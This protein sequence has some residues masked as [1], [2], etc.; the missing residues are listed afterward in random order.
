MVERRFVQRPELCDRCVSI[1]GRLK[2]SH[3]TINVVTNPQPA[4]AVVD[5]G[6]DRRAAFGGWG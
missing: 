5:L 1:G 2:V 6:A 3:E 4:D